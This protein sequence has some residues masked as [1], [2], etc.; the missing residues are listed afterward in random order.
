MGGGEEIVNESENEINTLLYLKGIT[1]KGLLQCLWQPRWEGCL[2][3]DWIHV[4]ECLSCFSVHLNY[5]NIIKWTCVH[6]QSFNCV[7][8]FAILAPVAHGI[9]HTPIKECFF[10]FFF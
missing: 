8:L 10:F 5:Q 4:Y 9:F 2:R 6:A 1:N 3:G 7:Q